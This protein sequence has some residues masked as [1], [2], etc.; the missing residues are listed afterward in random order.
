MLRL[1]GWAVHLPYHV[2]WAHELQNGLG[3]DEPRMLTVDTPAAIP[4][5]VARLRELARTTP[6]GGH[7]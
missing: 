6:Q 7:S 4:A 2:T 3:A 1:G 5:A